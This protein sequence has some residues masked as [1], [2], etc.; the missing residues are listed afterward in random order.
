MDKKEM[1]QKA[2]DL[3]FKYEREYRGCAQC[4]V[5]AMQDVLGIQNDL[6]YKS[7][8]GLAGGTGECID[9]NCGGYSGAV[10]MMSLLFGRTRKEEATEFGRKEKYDSFRMAAALHDK[11]VEKYGSAVC[12]GVQTKIYGRAFDLRDDEQKQGFRDAGAHE[13]PDKCCAV[14]GDGARWG[15]ELILDEIERLGLSLEE[16]KGLECKAD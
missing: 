10:M 4:A 6:V 9:G 5:S 1:M 12:S 14:V 13:L 7:A 15:V 8:S 16:F 3:G 2:Y 11:Y